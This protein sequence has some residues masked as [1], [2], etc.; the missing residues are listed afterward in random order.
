MLNKAIIQGRFT[1][2]LELRNTKG[3]TAVCT[4]SLA[5]E[6]SR[7]D[8]NGNRATDFIDVVFW[9]KTAEMAAQRFH[10]GDMAMICGRLESRKWQ[11]RDGNNRVSWEVQC[12]SIA[13]CGGKSQSDNRAPAQTEPESDFIAQDDDSDVPF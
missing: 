11:D 1:K 3:G 13:F 2:D 12:E 7:K 10:K 9:G 4:A 6:R 8:A 5:C